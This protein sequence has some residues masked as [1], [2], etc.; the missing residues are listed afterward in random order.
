MPLFRA[1]GLDTANTWKWDLFAEEFTK[2]IAVK[3]VGGGVYDLS[4]ASGKPWMAQI[5]LNRF[6]DVAMSELRTASK[7]RFTTTLA[8]LER[9]AESAGDN[10]RAAVEHLAIFNS[11]NMSITS[12]ELFIRRS[13][14]ES[15]AKIKEQM[16]MVAR[17]E[18]ET[19]RLQREKFVLPAIVISPAV[20]PVRPKPKWKM[21]LAAGFLGGLLIGAGVALSRKT[22]VPTRA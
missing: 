18:L 19:M 12:P 22:A 8:S 2:Q 9:A 11:R 7:E 1:I 16:Y 15:E 17:Q 5:I 3:P 21:L 4:C 14:L 10:R 13:Q 20:L 6:Y